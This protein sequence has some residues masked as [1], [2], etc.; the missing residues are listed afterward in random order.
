[1]A[2]GS[3]RI[4]AVALMLFLPAV[5]IAEE[6]S[7]AAPALWRVTHGASTLYLFGSLH[8][9][10]DGYSWRTPQIDAALEASDLFI[11]EVPVDEA[12]LRDEKEYIVQNG[13]LPQHRTLKGMLSATEFETYSAVLRRAGL[14][15]QQFER[16]RPWLAAVTMGLAYLHPENLASLKGAD[17][18]VMTYARMHGRQLIYLESMKEQMELLTSGDER[19][20]LM[21]LKNLILHLPSSR[22]EEKQ[23][24][25]TWEKGD[26]TRFTALLDTYFKDHPEAQEKLVNQRNRNW[27]ASFKQ[28]LERPAGTT[29]VT[30]GAAHIGGTNGLV[31]ML[32]HEGYGVTRVTTPNADGESAC[33]PG[34]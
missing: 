21:A 27:L 7:H 30:V 29:M 11:F 2:G 3:A 20:H 18:E 33:G 13:I 5:S 34:A 9:L 19:R 6:V 17:D 1:M 10:P 16:Y 12:A 31:A 14:R 8:I 24:V 32:C 25:E 4:F 15:P 26:V 22:D 23:L 28:L